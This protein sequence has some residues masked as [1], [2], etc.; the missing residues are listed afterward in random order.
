M[1]LVG[2]LSSQLVHRQF[3]E[4]FPG[5]QIHSVSPDLIV[6]RRSPALKSAN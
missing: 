2:V 1:G 3:V 5:R 4:D 6:D